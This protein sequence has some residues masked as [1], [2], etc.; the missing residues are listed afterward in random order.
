MVIEGVM[1]IRNVYLGKKILITGHTGFKGCWLSIWLKNMGADVIGLSNGVPTTP[2]MF[3]MLN[4]ENKI[5]TI[6]ADIRDGKVI[7]EVLV[8]ERPDFVFHLAAQ[9]IVSKSYDDPIETIEANVVGTANILDGLRSLN[10]PCTAIMITSDKCY[11][12]VEWPWGYRESDSL[13]GKDIYSASKACAEI[14]IHSFISSYF[15]GA[16]QV[17]IASARAGNVIGGGDWAKDRIVPD[18]IRA[19]QNKIPVEIRSPDSTRPWQH[20]LEPLGGYLLLGKALHENNK[21]HGE[22]YNFGPKAEQGKKVVELIKDLFEYF[23]L[24]RLNS[25]YKI[26][27]N[28]PFHE[29]GLLKLNCDKALM[30]LKWMPTLD[31]RETI[32]FV[33]EWYKNIECQPEELYRLTEMQ[34]LKFEKMATSLNAA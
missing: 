9:A 31:Y 3:E 20:V 29:A 15:K 6:W 24:N 27:G 17:R 23:E 2:S 12:N 32:N 5:R 25:A 8:S 16:D 13:G 14:L 18:C 22:S 21:F 7:Q 4:L 28:I 10:N 30:D 33:G 34:I 19:W 1:S 11:E 26:V